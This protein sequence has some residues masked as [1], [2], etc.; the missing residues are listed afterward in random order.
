MTT[1]ARRVLACELASGAVLQLAVLAVLGTALQLGPSSWLAGIAYGAV[2]GVVL[3]RALQQ[4]RTP[5]LGPANR[6]TLARAALVG[7][8]TAIVADSNTGRGT[9][10]LVTLGTVA[11]VLDAVDGQVARRAGAASALGAR[12]DMEVDAFLILVLSVVVA[13]DLGVWVLA[14]GAMR[15]VFVGAMWIMPWLRAPLPVSFARK[16]VAA[17]QGIVLVAASADV[18]PRPLTAGMVAIA[19]MLL[20]WSFGRDVIWLWRHASE[21]GLAVRGKPQRTDHAAPL[22]P[23]QPA[24]HADK[25]GQHVP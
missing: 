16:T 18:L 10:A 13:R 17:T 12:F 4:T 3:L 21:R 6:V 25:D 23:R 20:A 22:Q 15:Y 1:P 7:G 24:D 5:S 14:I 8:V 19:L 11:L 9:L 2:T